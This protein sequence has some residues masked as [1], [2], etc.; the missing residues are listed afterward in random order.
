MSRVMVTTWCR[1]VVGRDWVTVTEA[2]KRLRITRTAVYNRIKRGTLQTQ[3]DN[4]GHQ[5]VNIDDTVTRDTLRHV[6]DDTV[7]PALNPELRQIAQGAADLVPVSVMQD[8]VERLSAAFQG[9][10][11]QL[12]TDM[13]EQQAR[14]RADQEA[15]RQRHLAEIER[16]VGQVQAERVFWIERA[17]AAEIRAEAAERRAAELAERFSRP[18]WRRLFG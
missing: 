15:E 5:L 1:I 3:T 14:Q 10:I 13:A 17:D 6:T 7:T 12:R 2:A 8:A 11:D 18:W 4:H 16:L 9:Q